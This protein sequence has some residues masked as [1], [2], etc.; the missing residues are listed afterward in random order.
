MHFSLTQFRTPQKGLSVSFYFDVVFFILCLFAIPLSTGFSR[1]IHLKFHRALAVA[2]HQSETELLNK[3]I[4]RQNIGETKKN[5]I[6]KTNRNKSLICT[7]FFY[8]ETESVGAFEMCKQRVAT[9]CMCFIVTL[10]LT[11]NRLL[12]AKLNHRG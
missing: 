10:L 6:G 2:I 7:K 12:F 4:Q 5:R 1:I 3:S 11:Q 9:W 8:T